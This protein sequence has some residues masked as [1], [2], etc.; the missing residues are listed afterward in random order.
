MKKLLSLVSSAAIF[1]CL[2]AC[3]TD[4]F[5]DSKQST[6]V[7]ETQKIFNSPWENTSTHIILDESASTDGHIA[8]TVTDLYVHKDFDAGSFDDFI[9]CTDSDDYE[10]QNIYFSGTPDEWRMYAV[11]TAQ[12]I[13]TKLNVYCNSSIDPDSD[14]IQ[15]HGDLYKE[16]GKEIG[17]QST[18]NE[19]EFSISF[20]E[21][22]ESNTVEVSQHI[23]GVE[24]FA[25]G[26]VADDHGLFDMCSYTKYYV[27]LPA[28]KY[29]IQPNAEYDGDLFGTYINSFCVAEDAFE[30]YWM[31]LDASWGIAKA[32]NDIFSIRDGI[33]DSSV[34]DYVLVNDAATYFMDNKDAIIQLEIESNNLV[35]IEFDKNNIGS[36]VISK[37]SDDTTDDTTAIES[38]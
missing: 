33:D 17:N 5:I 15:V 31:R 32:S 19:Y 11:D 20:S 23:D 13:Y 35:E 22:D 24:T 37:L 4:T 2:T 14:Y 18:E 28:G 3:G 36:L 6:D 25:R 16:S 29:V 30:Q 34:F 9:L 21:I 26:D 8:E 27:S 38:N 12:D 10:L 1:T 7:I